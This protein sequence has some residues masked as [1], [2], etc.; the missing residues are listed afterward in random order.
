[1]TITNTDLDFGR[2]ILRVGPRDRPFL[3]VGA[4]PAVITACICAAAVVLAIYGALSGSA[5]ITVAEGIAA[6]RGQG[7]SFTT[8]IVLEWR[9]PRILIALVLG[10]SLAISGAIFQ[11]LTSNPL[12]SPDV[13]GFQTGSYTG[14]LIVMLVLGGGSIATMTGALAGGI[15]TAFAVF[16]LASK[17]GFAGGVRLIIVGI[18]VSAMLA[19]LNVWLLLTATVEDAI[20]A[21]LWGAGNLSGTSWSTFALAS[22]GSVLFMVVAVLLAR[23]M[24]LQQIGIPFATALGQNVRI[25]QIVA[26]VAGIG[27]TALSTATVGPISFIALAAPQIARRLTKT[28]GLALAPT[29]AVGAFLLLLADVVA[30]RINPDSPLPVGIVTVSIGGAYFL[31]LLMREGRKK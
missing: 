1:M 10:A 7:D 14:A 2:R 13:I 9:A 21:S 30:Q 25:V 27:L 18:G 28:D 11:N 29:A 16:F 6:L 3:L 20:M 12:G 17:R 8:M 22:S 15:V 31:W 4:R 23:P 26:I 19:S 24:R 5:E